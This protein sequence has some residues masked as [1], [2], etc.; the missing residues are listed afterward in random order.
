MILENRN[1]SWLTFKIF[2]PSQYLGYKEC[3]SFRIILEDSIRVLT[4]LKISPVKVGL[5]YFFEKK[6]FFKNPCIDIKTRS[7]KTKKEW[8]STPELSFIFL[9]CLKILDS[10]KI[11]K[12]KLNKAF[13][14]EFKI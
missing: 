1:S 6:E 13:M 8:V 12:E 5:K 10:P 2:I 9:E 3:Y 14:E 11:L 7:S 4:K